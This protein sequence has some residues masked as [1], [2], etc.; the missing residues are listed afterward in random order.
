MQ[1]RIKCFVEVLNFILKHYLLSPEFSKSFAMGLLSSSKGWK[2]DR[3]RVHGKPATFKIYIC[4]P[5]VVFQFANFFFCLEEFAN[6]IFLVSRNIEYLSRRQH[7]RKLQFANCWITNGSLVQIQLFCTYYENNE[8]LSYFDISYLFC[9]TL[10]WLCL[11]KG[12]ASSP[13]VE[14]CYCYLNNKVIIPKNNCVTHFAII[15]ARICHCPVSILRSNLIFLPWC[16]TGRNGR[17]HSSSF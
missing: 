15:A 9:R 5:N 12:L 1:P 3:Q 17:R 11:A 14:Y 10:V 6:A 16:Y 2:W 8:R 4:N 7:T 13:K